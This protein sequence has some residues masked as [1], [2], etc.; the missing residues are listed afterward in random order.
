MAKIKKIIRE[1]SNPTIAKIYESSTLT[2]EQL[3]EF[4]QYEL[5]TND[6]FPNWVNTLNFSFIKEIQD[7]DEEKSHVYVLTTYRLER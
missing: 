2:N 3:S 6:V 5:G 1:E 4:E 7:I